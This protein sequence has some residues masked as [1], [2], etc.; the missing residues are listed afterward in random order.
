MKT[1]KYILRRG[2]IDGYKPDNHDRT[3]NYRIIGADTVGAKNIEISIGEIE[4]G[5]SAEYHAHHPIEQ[6]VYVIEGEGEG[7]ID[8]QTATFRTGDWIFVPAGAFHGFTA[9]GQT[10]A[11]LLV[12]YSPPLEKNV[13]KVIVA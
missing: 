9:T 13:D 7:M 2:D 4:P 10:P 12:I 8:G 11:R 3:V 6:V 5:G 1:N